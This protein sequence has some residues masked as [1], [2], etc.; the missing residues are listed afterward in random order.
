MTPVTRPVFTE[1]AGPSTDYERLQQ[2]YRGLQ[3]KLQIQ[4]QVG[5]C[6]PGP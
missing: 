6:T 2:S 1:A 5:T 4:E 3:T